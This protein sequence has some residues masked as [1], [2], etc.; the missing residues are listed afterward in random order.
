L[1]NISKTSPFKI[2][3]DKI[4][5]K[6]CKQLPFDEYVEQNSFFS[7]GLFNLIKQFIPNLPLWTG[8][9]I[10][11]M[12]LKYK[13]LKTCPLD[14]RRL[15]SNPA[16]GNFNILKN[17]I[18]L[19]SGAMP[20]EIAALSYER[21]L[22]KFDRDYSKRMDEI[23]PNLIRIK[24]LEE[25]DLPGSNSIGKKRKIFKDFFSNEFFEKWKLP[26]KQR[27]QA[28]SYFYGNESNISYLDLA[29]DFGIDL[30][31]DFSDIFSGKF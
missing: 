8:C 24:Q 26:K 30:N 5:R 11:L 12:K 9:F 10:S 22:F 25:E 27:K 21:L 13:K 6:K 3:F 7:P 17:K 18:V 2:H 29:A 19:K 14:M 4:I 23:S 31:R 1:K 28:D 16:E 20:S 15:N